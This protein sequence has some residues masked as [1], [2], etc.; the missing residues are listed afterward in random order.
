MSGGGCFQPD[1]NTYSDFLG[2]NNLQSGS[3]NMADYAPPEV[4]TLLAQGEA[5]SN[6]AQRF[7]VYSKLFQRLQ[8]DEPYIGLFQQES[9]GAISPKF[10]WPDCSP[11]WFQAR[12]A[13]SAEGADTEGE[14]ALD[15]P[16]DRQAHHQQAR[17]FEPVRH[18]QAAGVQRAQAEALDEL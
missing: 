5:T 11:W 13:R 7:A 1:P 4:D 12:W 17:T 15:G 18:L 8:T 10:K 14:V 3:W 2:S 6:P 16:A 9:T